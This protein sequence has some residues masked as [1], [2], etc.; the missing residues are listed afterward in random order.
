MKP[1]SD[2]LGSFVV[3]IRNQS[4]FQH[5]LN[6]L[7]SKKSYKFHFNIVTLITIMTMILILIVCDSVW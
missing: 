2:L 5:V 4:N 3:H 1:I 7:N 6:T